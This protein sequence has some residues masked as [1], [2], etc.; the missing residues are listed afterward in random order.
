MKAWTTRLEESMSLQP[1]RFQAKLTFRFGMV[2]GQLGKRTFN[3]SNFVS[4][5]T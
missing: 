1:D 2:S 4:K 5:V 3:T